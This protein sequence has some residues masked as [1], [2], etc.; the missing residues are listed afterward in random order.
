MA[1]VTVEDCVTQVPNVF[2]LVHLAARRSR[3]ISDGAEPL[4][5]WNND[6]NTIV[7]LRELAEGVVDPVTIRDAIIN[8]YRNIE[9][10]DLLPEEAEESEVS[11]PEIKVPVRLSLQD[12]YL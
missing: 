2:E 8:D 4:L 3:Q 12:A 1:R 7:A 9:D 5:P 11:L 10:E 6:K